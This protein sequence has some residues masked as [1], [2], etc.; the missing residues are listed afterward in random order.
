M[1]NIDGKEKFGDD[2]I[3]TETLHEICEGN[4]THTSIDKRGA[5]PE[6]RDRIKQKKFQ[7][8]GALRATQ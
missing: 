4:Q 5:R 3:S 2:L 6:I 1:E 8:K 7:W